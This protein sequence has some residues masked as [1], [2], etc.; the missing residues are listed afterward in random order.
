M[1]R[2]FRDDV[3]D[4]RPAREVEPTRHVRPQQRSEDK[5]LFDRHL[6]LPRGGTRERVEGRDHDHLLNEDE[7]RALATIGAFR[8]VSVDDL[9]GAGN[10]ISDADLRHLNDEGLITR[11]TLTDS[12]G[13]QHIVSLTS[14]GKGLLDAH[15]DP[16]AKGPEQAFYAGVVKPRELA[17]DSQ[18]YRAFKEE[19]ERIEAEGGRDRR[20]K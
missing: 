2:D 15:R 9:I 4:E 5:D 17:H 19:E 13:S 12:A 8:V 10:D 11:E 14:E 18:V 20:R 3:R 16:H 6:D 7:T 1:S